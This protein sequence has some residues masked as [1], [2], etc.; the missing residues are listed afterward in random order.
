V[1]EP[2]SVD[3]DGLLRELES[4]LLSM[5]TA[6]DNR[7]C[8]FC[9]VE[10]RPMRRHLITCPLTRMAITIQARKWQQNSQR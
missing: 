7:D 4:I 1:V 3:V 5:L 8:F 10:P 9:D 6:L 2:V